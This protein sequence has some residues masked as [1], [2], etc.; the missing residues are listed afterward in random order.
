[1]SGNSGATVSIAERVGEA[2]DDDRVVPV[3]G[4]AAQRLLALGVGLELEL[5]VLDAGL[6]LEALGALEGGLVE[7]AVELAAEVED[8]RRLALLR[9]GRAAAVAISAAAE[10][11]VFA[12]VI[13]GNLQSA[14]QGFARPVSVRPPSCRA[15]AMRMSQ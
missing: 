5:V 15:G 4:E 10:A 8:H 14:A 7:R 3:L 12:N 9:P 2:G 1:M 6:L 13:G 11:R